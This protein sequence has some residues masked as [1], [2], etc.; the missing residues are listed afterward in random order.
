MSAGAIIDEVSEFGWARLRAAQAAKVDDLFAL[1]RID[2]DRAQASMDEI[3]SEQLARIR[4]DAD[5][6]RLRRLFGPR[7]RVLSAHGFECPERC[8]EVCDYDP[9]LDS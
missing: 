2:R 4:H 9:R 5:A 8:G 7:P 1:A 6:A 3:L